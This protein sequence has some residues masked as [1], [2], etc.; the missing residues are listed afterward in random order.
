MIA[1]ARIERETRLAELEA[2]A[3]V[4]IETLATPTTRPI[5]GNEAN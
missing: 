3:G 4:D 1:E 5:R 2:L